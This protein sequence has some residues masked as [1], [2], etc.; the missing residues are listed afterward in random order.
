[1]VGLVDGVG[2]VLDVVMVLVL[3]ALVL[4]G[5]DVGRAEVADVVV[6]DIAGAIEF[7]KE[8]SIP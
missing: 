8:D 5:E 6:V 3:V 4:D 7:N 2:V 1:V